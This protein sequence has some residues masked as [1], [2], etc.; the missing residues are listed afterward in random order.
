MELRIVYADTSF[1]LSH[2]INDDHT[3]D[4][5]YLIWE[6]PTALRIS[7]LGIL[8]YQTSLWRKVGID[9]F[10]RAHAERAIRL[11]ERQIAARWFVVSTIADGVIHERAKSLA[12]AYSSDLKVPSLDI[13]H[14]AVA[15]EMGVNEFW[16]FD[17]R[18]KRLAEAVGLKVNP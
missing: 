14:V 4:A 13:L 8:E 9:G 16:T 15:L 6:V 5:R 11:F 18:Q 17:G 1:L 12:A 3:D 7:S 2:F 10:T